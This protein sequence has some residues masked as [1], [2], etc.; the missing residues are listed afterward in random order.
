V[1]GHVQEAHVG[2]QLAQLLGVPPVAGQ[3]H[4]PA[5][6]GEAAVVVADAQDGVPE[7]PIQGLAVAL[8]LED[9]E[10]DVGGLAAAVLGEDHRR[11][12]HPVGAAGIALAQHEQQLA[13]GGGQ[14]A[15]EGLHRDVDHLRQP[16]RIVGQVHRVEVLRRRDHGGQVGLLGGADEEH[17]RSLL[18]PRDRGDATLNGEQGR[19]HRDR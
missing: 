18:D 10:E 7:V 1:Q 17:G 11:S 15:R 9:V 6:L 4:Q 2:Q 12:H 13:L 5:H 14:L 16:L 19:K 3:H 8:L